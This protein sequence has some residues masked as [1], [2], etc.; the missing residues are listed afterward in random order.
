MSRLISKIQKHIVDHSN[1]DNIKYNKYFNYLESPYA[2]IEFPELGDIKLFEIVPQ[3][4]ANSSAT[5]KSELQE[6]V[7]ASSNRTEKEIKHVLEVDKDPLLVFDPFLH[8][9]DLKLDRPLFATMYYNCLLAIV[10]HLKYFYNRARP[11]QIAPHLGY[12]ISVIQTSTHQTPSY[13]SGHLTE[14]AL[15]AEILSD[16]YPEHKTAF[17]EAA[18]LVGKARVLQGVH[19]PSDNEASMIL[20]RVGWENIKGNLDDKWTDII[21]E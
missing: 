18:G 20:A 7:R 12:V 4:K 19:Y 17:Y 13:P 5:T 16:I 21:K 10:D 9:H 3:P 14:G 11:F 6:V 1:I 8:K 2:S 15:I